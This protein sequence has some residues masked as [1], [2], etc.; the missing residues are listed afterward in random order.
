MKIRKEYSIAILV[1]GGAV[2]LIF[3]INFLKGLDLL[4]KR[5]VYRVMYVDVSGVTGS[6]PVFYNG[7]KV[8]QVIA[9]EMTED[10]TRRIMVSFQ[11]DEDHLPLTKQT[12][13]EIY[14]SDLF[15]R[16]LRIVL[17]KGEP[18][19]N[20]DTLIGDAQLSLTDAVGE[21]IDPL[22]RKAEGMLASID[23]VLSSLQLVLNDSAVGDIHA[24]FASVRS[25]LETFNTTAHRMDE[26]IASESTAIRAIIENIRT[27][28]ANLDQFSA[29]MGHVVQNLD[30]ASAV[31]ADGR[32]KKMM[33]DLSESST[34]L[35]TIMTGLEQGEG[36]LGALL[37]NDTLYANLEK[38]S[39]E[40]DLLLEDL[41]LNPNRYVHVSVFGKKDK[42]P[43]LS[44][45]DIDRIGKAVQEQQK[46]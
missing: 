42:L 11:L 41:R 33:A 17:A 40:L 37:K 28:S 39:K 45:S 8:G 31:L 18:A 35:K 44:D 29:E 23:S 34:Q 27:V 15:S 13:V 21:Q 7:Y 30:S 25:T 38:S 16:A 12:K 5:N 26:L 1:L 22:K 19:K 4:Q 6:T 24:S 10:S 36:T 3:G 9:T 46:K 20:G 2:L 43:K 14:S 32:L